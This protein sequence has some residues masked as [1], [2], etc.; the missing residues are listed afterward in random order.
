LENGSHEDAG[1]STSNDAE[2]RQLAEATIIAEDTDQTT[3][4]ESGSEAL[5]NEGKL[6]TTDEVVLDD[7]EAPKSDEDQLGAT[8]R[9]ISKKTGV[10]AGL[11]IALLAL[12]ALN[13]SLSKKEWKPVEES[14]VPVQIYL[15][16]MAK[17]IP[18]EVYFDRFII[19]LNEDADQAYLTMNLSVIP[20]SQSVY[21]E[22]NAKRLLCRAV[23]Y[24]VLKR[25]AKNTEILAETK[26]R[27]SKDII[28]ALNK[29]LATGRVK[30]V[31]FSEFLVV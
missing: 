10:F 7:L 26:T 28:Q 20:S 17:E 27:L 5:E 4:E 1:D 21:E 11:V 22:V 23:I 9:V 16:S 14:E 31:H 8:N 25:A 19:L 13:E 24:E 3:V 15:A 2:E 12:V 30:E 18:L 6:L 29:T